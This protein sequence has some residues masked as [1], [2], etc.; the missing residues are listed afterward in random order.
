VSIESQVP[1]EKP[2]SVLPAETGAEQEAVTKEPVDDSTLTATTDQEPVKVETPESP[3]PVIAEAKEEKPVNPTEAA[4]AAMSEMK[5]YRRGDLVEGAIVQVTEDAL[6]IDIGTKTEGIIRRDEVGLIP[7]PDL[8]GFS[9]GDKIS[10]VIINED[11]E[12][13]YHLSKRRADQTLVWEKVEKSLKDGIRVIATGFRA[14]K[15]GLLV[16]IGTIAF[17]PQ[18]LIDIRRIDDLEQFV[19]QKFEVKVVDYDREAKP[20]PKIVVSRRSILEEDLT[21]ERD[22]IYDGLNP[23]SIVDGKVIKLTNYGAFVDIGGLQGLLHI[24]EMSLGRIKHPGEVMKEGDTIKVKIIKIDKKR[25]RVSLGR[26]EL[27]PNPWDTINE[28]F[29]AGQVV[30]GIVVRTADFGAFVKIDDYFEGLAHIS[31]L[32]E[33]RI[34]HAKEVFT[35]G[36]KVDVL[37]MNIDKKN[38]RV[39]LS[40][41]R[42][43]QARHKSEVAEFMRT[44]GDLENVFASQLQAALDGGEIEIEPLKPKAEKEAVE[45]KEEPKEKAVKPKAEKEAVESKEEPKEKAVKPKAK[46]EVAES[47]EEP[48]AKAKKPKAKKEVVE[49]QEEPKAKAKKP[50]AKKEVVESQEEPKVDSE[51]AKTEAAKDIGEEAKAKEAET[52]DIPAEEIKAEEAKDE[53][54]RAEEGLDEGKMDPSTNGTPM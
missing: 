12:G 48:K 28:K 52:E 5:V 9:V 15:G 33:N 25:K 39:K 6:I 41:R 42:A 37:I 16:D 36:D 54:P 22:R 2:D 27:L 19:G 32:V 53:E 1:D 14:V 17:L 45:S 24:S 40:V 20:H 51:E 7:S 21:A 44:Q 29:K 43:A 18:S 38:K 4:L 23:G 50:K 11:D 31:E 35:A 26:R 49:S 13:T 3:E 8:S 10:A 47:L 46:K 34:S 30:E